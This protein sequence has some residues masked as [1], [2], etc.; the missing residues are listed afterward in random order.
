MKGEVHT[1]EEKSSTVEAFKKAGQKPSAEEGG[2]P[3]IWDAT[4]GV[5][6]P[7]SDIIRRR[8]YSSEEQHDTKWMVAEHWHSRLQNLCRWVLYYTLWSLEYKSHMNCTIA[9]G[10]EDSKE[11]YLR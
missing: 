7:L 3:V 10:F 1:G 9:A 5:S 11:D 2:S 4:L 6:I 8:P